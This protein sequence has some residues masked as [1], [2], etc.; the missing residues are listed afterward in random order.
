MLYKF[1]DNTYIEL[2]HIESVQ[3]FDE[4]TIGREAL[5]FRVCLTMKSGERHNKHFPNDREGAEKRLLEIVGL[6]N[7]PEK[8]NSNN[9]FKVDETLII[10]LDSIKSISFGDNPESIII[11]TWDLHDIG[12]VYH[13]EFPG[14]K[15]EALDKIAE[16]YK[17]NKNIAL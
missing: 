12:N 9:L 10:D 6:I 14:R 13:V 7:N 4:I 15:Q 1:T 16:I 3:V 8:I 2:N 11:I 17:A 5:P